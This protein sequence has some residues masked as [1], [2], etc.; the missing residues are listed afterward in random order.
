MANAEVLV[1]LLNFLFELILDV[2]VLYDQINIL[3]LELINLNLIIILPLPHRLIILLGSFKNSRLIFKSLTCLDQFEFI[4]VTFYDLGIIFGVDR[5]EVLFEYFNILILLLKLLLK[6]N[7]L[8][9][10]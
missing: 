2:L 6:S 1:E 8:L 10:F 3:L 9:M 4:I 7:E 5:L